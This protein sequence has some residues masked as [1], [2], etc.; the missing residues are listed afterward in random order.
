MGAQTVA[1]HRRLSK[2]KAAAIRLGLIVE[3]GLIDARQPSDRR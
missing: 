2:W 3:T 1:H